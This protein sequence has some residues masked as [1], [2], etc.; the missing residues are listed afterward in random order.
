[1]VSAS[2]NSAWSAFLLQMR[3]SADTDAIKSTTARCFAQN[4]VRLRE[5]SGLSVKTAASK[6]GVAAS[7][8]SQWETGKRFP[9]CHLFDHIV[10]MFGVPPCFLLAGSQTRGT[11]PP[12][13]SN[14]ASQEKI[15]SQN[16]KN[17]ELSQEPPAP[18]VN[19]RIRPT[20]S[21][22]PIQNRTPL[23]SRINLQQPPS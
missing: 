18:N 11:S 20:H 14:A 19:S 9:P 2:R 5:A 3:S 22:C 15:N 6:L 16:V 10:T 1:V 23:T 17:E 4:L 13:P 12:C 21:S 8:W 7:T